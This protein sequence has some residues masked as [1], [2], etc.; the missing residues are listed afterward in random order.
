MVFLIRGDLIVSKFAIVFFFHSGFPAWFKIRYFSTKIYCYYAGFQQTERLGRVIYRWA[1]A[2]EAFRDPQ[3]WMMCVGLEFSMSAILMAL[4]TDYRRHKIMMLSCEACNSFQ[5]RTIVIMFLGVS[6][7]F[8]AIFTLQLLPHSNHWARICGGWLLL[9]ISASHCGWILQGNHNTVC[10]IYY[11]LF[12]NHPLSIQ[13]QSI[14]WIEIS[15]SMAI[16]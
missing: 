2:F 8:V 3:V 6:A 16:Q 10:G 13:I 14:I 1:E 4:A 7:N 11:I 5:N 9:C 12:Q 15:K